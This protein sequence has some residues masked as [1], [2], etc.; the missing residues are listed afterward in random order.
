VR[1]DE[2]DSASHPT[3][4]GDQVFGR[5]IRLFS[6]TEQFANGNPGNLAAD[7]GPLKIAIYE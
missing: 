3:A 4:S 2:S 1:L 7:S 6:M 5:T